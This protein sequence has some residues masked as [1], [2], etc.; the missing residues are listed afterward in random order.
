M[1][2][3]LNS[4]LPIFKT[5]N[6][7]TFC[8]QHFKAIQFSSCPVRWI[9]TFLYPSRHLAGAFVCFARFMGPALLTT[10]LFTQHLNQYLAFSEQ[11]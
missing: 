11:L 6:Q 8:P 7:T 9:V 3:A 5:T 1:V 4:C 10:F 2:A